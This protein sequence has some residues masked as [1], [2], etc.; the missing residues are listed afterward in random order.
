MLRLQHD[1]NKLTSYTI[2]MYIWTR[3]P[4]LQENPV[5]KLTPTENNTTL[6]SSL[7]L[8]LFQAQYMYSIISVTGE[9]KVKTEN[10]K[11]AAVL[12]TTRNLWYIH[13]TCNSVEIGNSNVQ[14]ISSHTESALFN[15]SIRRLWNEK[16]LLNSHFILGNA[17][18]IKYS[19]LWSEHVEYWKSCC[20]LFL[21]LSG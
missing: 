6:S 4:D 13:C 18:V 15:S 12:W 8:F 1:Q 7:S 5:D 17:S 20:L 16:S 3:K 19:G 2:K 14:A 21:G 11:I 10:R 9:Q